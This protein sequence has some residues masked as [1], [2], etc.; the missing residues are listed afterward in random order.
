MVCVCFF[1]VLSLTAGIFH[2]IAGKML[3]TLMLGSKFAL[4][5]AVIH[6]T[7]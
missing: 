4:S 2:H 7:V 5:I 3:N 1:E 6:S